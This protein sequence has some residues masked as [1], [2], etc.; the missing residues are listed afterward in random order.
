MTHAE[1]GIAGPHTRAWANNWAGQSGRPRVPGRV[2]A[3]T[4][5]AVT[6]PQDPGRRQP[7]G[8]L[9][10]AGGHGRV[11]EAERQREPAARRVRRTEPHHER[12]VMLTECK[13]SRL[14]VAGGHT[15]AGGCGGGAHGVQFRIS[16]AA[17]G[18]TLA[19][20]GPATAI[21]W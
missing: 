3:I 13:A 8:P 10:R 18:A 16:A 19:V 12:Q 11:A 6:W 15:R 14:T 5:G 9:A 21:A 20:S 2:Q 17:M 1:A 4:E 7:P